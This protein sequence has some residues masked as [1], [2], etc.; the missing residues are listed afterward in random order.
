MNQQKALAIRATR[1]DAAD[2]EALAEFHRQA[3]HASTPDS[4]DTG[5]STAGA[6]KIGSTQGCPFTASLPAPA[7][8]VYNGAQIVGYLSSIPA[9]F[10]NGTGAIPA[11]WLKGFMVLESHRNGPIGFMLVKRMLE[12]VGTSG[13]M[14]VAPNA[15]RLLEALG[16][17]DAGAV[18]NYVTVA[19]PVRFLRAL[20]V[21]KLGLASLPAAL[22]GVLRTTRIA[23]VALLCGAAASCALGAIALVGKLRSVGLRARITAEPPPESAVD[24]LWERLR[25]HLNFAPSR[26]GAYITWRYAGENSSRYEYISL[27]SGTRLRALAVVRVAER[28]DDPRLAG[29]RLG[30]IVD[31]VLDPTDRPAAVAALLAAR[32]WGRRK[33]CDAIL[34]TLSHGGVGRLAIKVGYARIPGNVH[35]LLRAR[36]GALSGPE[37][38]LERSWLTR[39]DAWG[40]DI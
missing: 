27:Y 5:D 7:V 16:L 9:E 36:D 19:R 29:L 11:H 13:A 17:K 3:W 18:P 12:E 24:G 38:G 34:L 35:C 15:R 23:P 25:P 39:G 26:S 33:G 21:E 30:L 4:G 2:A 32:S 20:D 40:D 22:R 37:E 6:K 1:L 14:V 31:L 28:A 10:W 8:A